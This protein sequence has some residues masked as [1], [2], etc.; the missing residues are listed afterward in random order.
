MNVDGAHGA[1]SRAED[2]RVVEFLAR[3]RA[4]PGISVRFGE[5]SHSGSPRKAARA[6]VPSRIQTRSVFEIGDAAD[7]VIAFRFRQNA[8]A[9][10][11]QLDIDGQ[12]RSTIRASGSPS[13]NKCGQ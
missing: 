9:A 7:V 4:M 10:A 1:R 3:A 6:S 2:K 11:E 8:H 13:R 12:R 5:R